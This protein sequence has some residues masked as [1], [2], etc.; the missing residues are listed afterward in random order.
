[1]NPRLNA[2]STFTKPMIPK[3]LIGGSVKPSPGYMGMQREI[4]V[5]SSNEVTSLCI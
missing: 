2:S 1:M 3:Y 5:L 4:A